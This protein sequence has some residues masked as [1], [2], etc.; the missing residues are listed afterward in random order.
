MDS[1]L[2]QWYVKIAPGMN[3][4][5]E[6]LD[7]G[8]KWV[9]LAQNCRFE[10]EPRSV[11]KRE[12]VTYYNSDFTGLVGG[13]GDGP[14][15]GL[16][17]YYVGGTGYFLMVHKT[18]CYVGDDATGTWTPIRTG[19]TDGKRMSFETYQDRAIM[20]NGFDPIFVFDGDTTTATTW[21]LGACKAT[22]GGAG[23][24]TQT[25]IT[26]KVTFDNDAVI[27]DAVD[28][29]V[30]PNYRLV[31]TIADNSTTTYTDS[32]NDV[33]AGTILGAA[34]DTIPLGSILKIHRERLFI[35][36]DPSNPNRIYFSNVYR[37]HYIQVDTNLDYLEISPE[38]GD[39]I[40]GIPIQLGVMMCIKK[41]TI[42]RIHITSPTSG[43]DPNTWTADD[44]QVFTGSPAQWSIQQTP[45]GIIF[46]GWDSWY[47]FDGSKAEKIF[48]EFDTFKILPSSYS[49]V[50]G[51]YHKGI[52]LAA[53]TDITVASQFHDRI[54]RYNFQRTALSLDLWTST[55][56]SGANCFTA[57]SGDDETGELYYGDSVLG[58]VVKAKESEESYRL[59]TKTECELGTKSSGA[60][61][62]IFIGGTENE[63]FIEI[64]AESTADDIPE[65][66][67]IFWDSATTT[68]GT[69]WTEITSTYDDL[70]IVIDSATSPSGSTTSATTHSHTVAGNLPSASPPI[71]NTGDQ[72]GGNNNDVDPTHTHTFSFTSSS[73]QSELRHIKLRMFKSNS[74]LAAGVTEFPIG[75]IIMWDQVETPVGWEDLDKL[76]TTTGYYIKAGSTG[77][78]SPIASSHSH[79]YSGNSSARSNSGE[80]S[81]GSEGAAGTHYHTVSGTTGSKSLNDWEVSHVGFHMIKRIGETETWDGTDKYAYVLVDGS[82]TP[83]GWDIVSTTYDD[84]WLK[85]GGAVLP[86]LG[87]AANT[88]HTHVSNPGGTSGVST[89]LFG[90]T[91]HRTQ[92]IDDHSHSF[93]V[94]SVSTVSNGNPGTAKFRLFRRHLGKMTTFNLAG[95]STYT[96]GTW[97]SPVQQI[98]AESLD[99]LFW[100]VTITAPSTDDIV[101]N[102]RS[103]PTAVPD[104]SWTAWSADLTDPN[105]SIIPTAADS[106]VQYRIVFSADDTQNDNPRVY[107]TNAFVVKYTY[108]KGNVSAETSVNFHY[109]I[110]RRNFDDPMSDKIFKKIQSVHVGDSGSFTV[111]W[112]TENANGSFVIDLSVNPSKWDSFFQD[113]AMGR[114]INFKF[115]KNDLIDFKIKELKGIYTTEPTVL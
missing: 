26:Y 18:T 79:T 73:V 91:Y 94:S 114:E 14:V 107:F 24:I 106:Y 16:Y 23:G 90:T 13:D 17:R 103:G 27:S 48:D 6:D 112:D 93:T 53:Y 69:G 4:K 64:G 12:P 82:S 56:I 51:F 92:G 81:S 57:K 11:T 31:T 58:Y 1:E 54:M 33:S 80:S 21:E 88:T 32:T 113:T 105:G 115:S 38:D 55:T 72:G 39:E 109:D 52:F 47:R 63:P 46:L 83:T 71:V 36:G 102:I 34:T 96:S 43:A 59:R 62:G 65:D 8:D 104:G 66:L 98:N 10:N 89:P 29:N 110:G 75:A 100:N 67:I 5:T 77:L 86:T 78:N 22:V 3:N 15:T 37:P 9:Q 70:Y 76:G 50:V 25:G 28:S 99:K 20:S 97:T 108:A 74:S 111:D 30:T 95:T 101:F 2:Q 87:D 84:R 19:L 85:I 42:R 60:G 41:N 49:D 61:D 68:P 44:P 45:Y 40:M 7:L 35:S